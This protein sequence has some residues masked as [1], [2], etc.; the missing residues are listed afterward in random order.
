MAITAFPEFSPVLASP[1]ISSSNI[2]DAHILPGISQDVTCSFTSRDIIYHIPFIFMSF[3]IFNVPF[4]KFRFFFSIFMNGV[5]L[6]APFINLTLAHIHFQE[7]ILDSLINQAED[8]F[9]IYR[10]VHKYAVIS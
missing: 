6:N 4:I 7:S 3:D 8:E 10:F 1:A 2:I 5:S 9:D